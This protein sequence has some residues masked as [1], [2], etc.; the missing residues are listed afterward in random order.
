[1]SLALAKA[2]RGETAFVA[3]SKATLMSFANQHEDMDALRRY[4]SEIAD[5]LDRRGE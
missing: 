4:L 1:M 3:S 5:C 2:R